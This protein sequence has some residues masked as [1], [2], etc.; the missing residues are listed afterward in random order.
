MTTSISWDS[1]SIEEQLVLSLAMA[2]TATTQADKDEWRGTANQLVDLVAEVPNSGSEAIVQAAQSQ[3][4]LIRTLNQAALPKPTTPA[5]FLT[6]TLFL[7]IMSPDDELVAKAICRA[8][9]F[10]SG[11]T[12]CEVDA[13]LTDAHI[14]AFGP[15]HVAAN[16][17]ARHAIN[18][19][20]SR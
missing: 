8:K 4:D 20:M 3:A 5:E 13:C 1:M 12:N 6:R 14:R 10:A 11:M 16:Q 19:A 7:A 17:A 2:M 18:R 15:E 9:D